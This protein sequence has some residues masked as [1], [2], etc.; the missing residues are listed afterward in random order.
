MKDHIRDYSTA[1]FRF[2]ARWG[3][4]ENYIDNLSADL[5]RKRGVGACSPTEAELVKKEQ[6]LAEKF[7]EIADLEAVEK[8]LD[9]C[10]RHYPEVRQAVEIVYLDKPFQD[11][12]WGDIK[13]RVHYAEIHMPASERQV[14]RWLKKARMLFAEERGLRLWG[15]P[16]KVESR[17]GVKNSE[18]NTA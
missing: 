16:K 10:E 12:E 6:L 15:D 14:Y 1:A 13:K 8:V 4:K 2:W 9:I 11:L 5:Q 17:K 3:G 7:A 18:S